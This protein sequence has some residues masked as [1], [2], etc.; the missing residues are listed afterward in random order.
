MLQFPLIENPGDL[1]L[2]PLYTTCEYAGPASSY[3]PIAT[4]RFAYCPEEGAVFL[5]NSFETEPFVGGAEDMEGDHLV[6]AAFDFFPGSGGPVLRFAVNAEGRCRFYRDGEF[7]KEVRLPSTVVAMWEKAFAGC[8][9][10]EEINIPPEVYHVSDDVFQ[11]CE[12]LRRIIVE[13]TIE[14]RHWVPEGAEVVQ[15][16][17]SPSGK[18][19]V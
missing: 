6:S 15:S 19:L 4:V 5:F 9:S 1:E 18:N 17:L 12:S 10:L 11:G 16:G 13:G 14:S 3:M 2:V 7:L 8:R